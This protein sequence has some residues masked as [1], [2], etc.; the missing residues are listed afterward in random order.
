MESWPPLEPYDLPRYDTIINPLFNQ[1]LNVGDAAVSAMMAGEVA[2]DDPPELEKFWCENCCI[3]PRQIRDLA[4]NGC[5]LILAAGYLIGLATL[6]S[7]P[8]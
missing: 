4:T 6:A 8:A 3:T 5:M 1:A 7:G 2:N